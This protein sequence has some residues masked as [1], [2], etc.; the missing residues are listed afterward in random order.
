MNLEKDFITR[1]KIFISAPY[2]QL[3]WDKYSH[4]FRDY[5]VI[6]PDVEERMDEGM[7]IKLFDEHPDIVCGIVCDDHFTERVYDKSNLSFLVKW[8]TG[9]DSLNK[10]IALNYGVNIFNTPSA[11][12]IPVSES[13]IGM[14]LNFCRTIGSSD[15]E[16]KNG[17]WNKIPGFTLNES[18]VGIIGLGNIG[19]EVAKKLEIFGSD[20]SYYDPNVNNFKYTRYHNL[21]DMIK[22]CD[23]ITIH[24]DLN[25]SSFHLIGK[26]ELYLLENKV[27]INTARGGVINGHELEN[28]ITF[29]G[30]ISLGLDVFEE[31]PLPLDSVLRQSS[32]NVILSA[33]NTNTSPKFWK[34]VHMNSINMLKDNI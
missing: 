3:E 8:G 22:Y 4:Y 18:K 5:E 28:F 34:N 17:K 16:L 9:I 7:L 11:F 24:C 2:L 19:S 31:E 27:L 14:M 1:I 21:H 15:N 23:I 29:G 13:V 32:T 12:T 20:I 33:H 30:G 10:D 6:L 26:D 25:E